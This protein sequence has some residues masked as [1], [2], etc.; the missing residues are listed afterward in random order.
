MSK[1]VREDY[2]GAVEQRFIASCGHEDSFGYFAGTVCGRCAKRNHRR[3]V[4]G[5]RR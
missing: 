1:P 2:W 5:S 4:R 3:A